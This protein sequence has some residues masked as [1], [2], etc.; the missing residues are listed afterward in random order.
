MLG[1]A[2]RWVCAT[3]NGPQPRPGLCPP[4]QPALCT[5][6]HFGDY[7]MRAFM[8][9]SID[10]RTQLQM[11]SRC[12]RVKGR[13]LSISQGLRPTCPLN[14][15][16]N[17]NTHVQHLHLFF[18]HAHV[19]SDPAGRANACMP[20]CLRR[21]SVAEARRA[22]WPRRRK[23]CG[24][25]DAVPCVCARRFTTCTHTHTHTCTCTCTCTCAQPVHTTPAL[26]YTRLVPQ[27]GPALKA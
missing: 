1:C 24:A 25:G 18:N 8:H 7:M 9:E 16:A 20:L 17:D 6:L 14:P 11:L 22:P 21:A 19:L 5:T 15:G 26:V 4:Y 13:V 12:T 2:P 23:Q 3:K 27:T 10:Q